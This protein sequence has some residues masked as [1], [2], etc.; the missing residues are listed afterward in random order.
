[1]APKEKG[2]KA[3]PKKWKWSDEM[4]RMLLVSIKEYKSLKEFEGVD[5]E[6]DLGHSVWKSSNCA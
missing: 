5:F 1:M 3:K 2:A 4:V 6:A